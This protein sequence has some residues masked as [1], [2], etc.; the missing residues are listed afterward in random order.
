MIEHPVRYDQRVSED[1]KDLADRLV[2]LGP[3]YNGHVPM[4]AVYLDMQITTGAVKIA[5]TGKPGLYREVPLMELADQ[6]SNPEARQEMRDRY[7]DAGLPDTDE[8]MTSDAAAWAIHE[9]HINGYLVMDD[10]HVLNLAIPPKT[11]GAKWFLN[12]HEEE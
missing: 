4:A 7:P 9:L 5:V 8:I 11:P 1:A 3:R 12:G 6:L 2:K 10:Q